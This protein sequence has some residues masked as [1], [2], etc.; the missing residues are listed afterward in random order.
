MTPFTHITAFTA[1]IWFLTTD[2][3]E[4]AFRATMI[5]MTITN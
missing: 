4:L 1:L 3:V 2:P 5:I